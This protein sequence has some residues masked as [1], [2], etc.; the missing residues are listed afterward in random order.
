MRAWQII[1]ATAATFAIVVPARAA[2]T[3]QVGPSGCADGWFAIQARIISLAP[4]TARL[5]KSRG[6]SLATTPVAP[7]AFLCAGESLV[8]DPSGGPASVELLEAGKVT[9]VDSTKRQY[10]VRGDLAASAAGVGAFLDTLLSG[11]RLLGSPTPRGQVN[12]AR[13]IPGAPVNASAISQ[14]SAIEPLKSL[15]RQKLAIDSDTVVGWLDGVGPFKCETR[16]DDNVAQWSSAPV[17]VQWC[18]VPIRS[19]QT[20]RVAVREA[21]GR[22]TG[23]QV[24]VVDATEIPRPPPAIRTGKDRSANDTTAWAI[25]LWQKGGP[26]WRLQAL[27]LAASVENDVFLARHFVDSVLAEIPLVSPEK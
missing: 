14:A 17:G 18:K 26:E 1:L 11:A 25:W 13:G 6:G 2:Q 8:F 23:W 3:A 5:F 21:G 10:T 16:D 27:G 19:R 20:V 24:Q 12:G 22:S 9:R 4:P 7:G 15:P